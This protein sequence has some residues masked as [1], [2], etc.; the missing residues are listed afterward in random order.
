MIY[1]EEGLEQKTIK[2]FDR[3]MSNYNLTGKLARIGGFGSINDRH[4]DKEIFEY[5]ELPIA[6]DKECKKVYKTFG[7]FQICLKASETKSPC[8]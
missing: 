3:S 2:I 8:R 4:E 6:A 1:V 5:V 7:N